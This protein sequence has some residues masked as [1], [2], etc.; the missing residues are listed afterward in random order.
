MARY[1]LYAGIPAGTGSPTAAAFPGPVRGPP[2]LPLNNI[3]SEFSGRI[4]ELLIRSLSRFFSVECVYAPVPGNLRIAGIFFLCLITC[5][6][7][8]LLY[9]NLCV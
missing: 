7:K 9:S 8:L 6:C 2:R 3:A 5:I 4:P 1:I